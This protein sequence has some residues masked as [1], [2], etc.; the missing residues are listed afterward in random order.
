M[1]MP[2]KPLILFD[3]FPRNEAYTLDRALTP[4]SVNA[5]YNNFYEFGSGKDIA[6]LAQKLP[7]RTKFVV[8]S[9]H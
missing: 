5:E 6:S 9:V 2:V 3:P 4:E 7:I 8:R 1:T